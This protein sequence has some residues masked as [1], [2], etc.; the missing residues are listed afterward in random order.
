MLRSTDG[1]WINLPLAWIINDMRFFFPLRTQPKEA[2]RTRTLDEFM[3]STQPWFT[4]ESL[5]SDGQQEVPAKSVTT[6][7]VVH[8]VERILDR[9]RRK[10][11]FEYYVQWKGYDAADNTWEPERNLAD[12]GSRTLL[13]EFNAVYAN[14][15]LTSNLCSAKNDDPAGRTTC[16]LEEAQATLDADAQDHGEMD[17]AQSR[18]GKRREWAHRANLAKWHVESAAKWITSYATQLSPQSQVQPGS[19]EPLS[20]HVYHVSPGM[21]APGV[22]LDPDEPGGEVYETV[23]QLMQLQNIAG[24]PHDFIPGYKK[25][26]ATV[27]KMR[28]KEV[29]PEVAKYV[30]AKKLAVRLRMLLEVKRDM[31]RKGRLVL[32][33]F[34]APSWWRVGSTDSPVV[35][36]A[37][38]RAMIFRRDKTPG[39]REILSQFDFDVAFLQANG[40][41]VHEPTRH[42]SYRPHPGYPEKIYEL[43]GPLYGSDDAPMRF[44]NTVAPWLIAMGF[45]QAKNDPCMFTNETTGV[46]VGLHV[47]DGL[48]RGTQTAVDLILLHGFSGAIQL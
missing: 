43:T 23:K 7:A 47:D 35:A 36:T 18:K 34:R 31:R 24:D 21:E 33:G 13:Q 2:G 27:T 46:Q 8:E 26:L 28:L 4:H 5:G 29:S 9:R 20:E 42:V 19:H 12:Y 38:L 30:R 25:E 3:E 17:S 44:F 39:N 10:K 11:Q 32:Q 1:S 48:V 45:T 14:K 41:T 6:G 15:H 40:F 22:H 16:L 37:G